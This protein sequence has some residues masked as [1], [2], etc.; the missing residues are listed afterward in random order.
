MDWGLGHCPG[1]GQLVV[2]PDL[3]EIPLELESI[4]IQY[5]LWVFLHGHYGQLIVGITSR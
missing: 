4:L 1:V 5:C 3:V 2:E